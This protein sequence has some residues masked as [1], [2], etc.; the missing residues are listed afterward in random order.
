MRKIKTEATYSHKGKQFN[1]LDGKDENM[2]SGSVPLLSSHQQTDQDV[3][4][5]RLP[6]HQRK[7]AEEDYA[8]Y[9]RFVLEMSIYEPLHRIPPDKWEDEP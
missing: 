5:S 8:E 3:V 7:L 2:L 4:L 1:I 6:P 9:G